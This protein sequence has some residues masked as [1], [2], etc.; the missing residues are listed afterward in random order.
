MAWNNGHWVN[1]DFVVS[2]AVF[3]ALPNK[4]TNLYF[5]ALLDTGEQYSVHGEDSIAALVDFSHTFGIAVSGPIFEDLP[6]GYDVSSAN[7]HI[8]GNALQAVPL[9]AT[10][11]M[12]ATALLTLP[13][14]RRTRATP[15][16]RACGSFST[17][18][19][20]KCQAIFAS[21]L[22][23]LI[24]TAC[25]SRD[26]PRQQVSCVA[27]TA[28]QQVLRCSGPVADAHDPDAR[29]SLDFVMKPPPYDTLRRMP[30]LQDVL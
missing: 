29:R 9:P 25:Q 2:T 22:D 4:P 11:P 23:R 13:R 21:R 27:S 8:A 3:S 16:P 18:S 12:L 7:F 30:A 17:R 5:A 14:T 26:I 20:W 15:R 1:G 24:A 28:D 19:E 6:A 10:L